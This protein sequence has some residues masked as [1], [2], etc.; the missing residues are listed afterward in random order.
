MLRTGSSFLCLLVAGLLFTYGVTGSGKTF[1]M[2]GSPGQGGL[3][4]RALDMLFNNIGAYQAKRFVRRDFFFFLNVK[5]V[6]KTFLQTYIFQI[7]KPDDKNG[8]EIQNEVDAL[9]ERQRRDNN[10]T[11]PKTPASRYYR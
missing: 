8:M 11:F 1:T 4:P 7:F 3:L 2:T 5:Y 9:L 10:L 6:N